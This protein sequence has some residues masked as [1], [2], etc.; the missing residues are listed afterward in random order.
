MK[1]KLEDKSSYNA[2]WQPIDQHLQGFKKIYLSGDGVYHQMNVGTLR[3][4][5][6]SY[7]GD[8]QEFNLVSSTRAISEIKK[9][10]RKNDNLTAYIFGNPTFDLSHTL[11]ESDVNERG[12]T[13]KTTYT[14]AT[15]LDN[16]SFAS[17][18]QH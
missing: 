11:I 2:F 1:F 12:L 6:G 7:I 14:R 9:R 5:D 15:N 17:L 13:R 3:K 8:G 10:T 4:E 16:F 18:R